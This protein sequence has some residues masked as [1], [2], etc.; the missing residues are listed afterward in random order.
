MGPE[1][2]DGDDRRGITRD[3]DDLGTSVDEEISEGKCSF[4]DFIITLVAVRAPSVIA[5]IDDGLIGDLGANL[6]KD[7]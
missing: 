3:H 5:D 1:G 7:G 4:A 6:P 2:S